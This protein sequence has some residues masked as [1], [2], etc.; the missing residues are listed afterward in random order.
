MTSSDDELDPAFAHFDHQSTSLG[1]SLDDSLLNDIDRGREDDDDEDELHRHRLTLEDELEFEQR[2]DELELL[3]HGF[4][5]VI[6]ADDGFDG[7]EEGAEG[8]QGEDETLGPRETHAEWQQQHEGTSNSGYNHQW[9]SPTKLDDELDAAETDTGDAQS[10]YHDRL[11]DGQDTLR[12]GTAR[13]SSVNVQQLW[14]ASSASSSTT[15][16]PRS[17]LQ[18]VSTTTSVSGLESDDFDNCTDDL[19]EATDVIPVALLEQTSQASTRFLEILRV[20]TTREVDANKTPSTLSAPTFDASANSSQ[21]ALL[22]FIDRQPL[23]EK[24]ASDVIKTIQEEA[25]QRESQLQELIELERAFSRGDA[26]WQQA[27]AGIE[28]LPDWTPISAIGVAVVQQ[29]LSPA[30][31][32]ILTNGDASPR[33][34][35]SSPALISDEMTSLREAT[36]SFIA[37]L[38]SINEVTQVNTVAAADVGRK[39]RAV[40]NQVATLAE[41]FASYER[42]AAFVERD[43]A[44]QQ[45]Q[46]VLL[47]R[48][49]ADKAR[50]IVAD[51]EQRLDESWSKAV[52]MLGVGG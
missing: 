22:G 14:T 30:V 27:L 10:R 32:P 44:D 19:L 36:S 24:L 5:R 12:L 39:L 18:D 17:S 7:D 52:T 45:R 23:L 3:G 41:D 43:F 47:R 46:N 13:R 33:Q 48:K 35:L 9:D 25:R 8:G 51:V 26:A 28:A 40:R 38:S 20:H 50:D 2:H 49:K 21:D 31:S 29:A 4:G 34:P 6:G 37:S 16:R 42:S 1:V 15:R 11:E